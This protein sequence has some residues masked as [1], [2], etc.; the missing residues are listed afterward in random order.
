MITCLPDDWKAL[1]RYTKG[2]YE[3]ESRG[4]NNGYNNTSTARRDQS[5]ALALD[6]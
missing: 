6:R 4:N 5:R 2:S 1:F 3:K